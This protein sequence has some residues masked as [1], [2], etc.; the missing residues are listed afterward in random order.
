MKT[1]KLLVGYHKPATLLKNDFLVPIHLG[2]AVAEKSA[3]DGQL[4][5]KELQWMFDNM[6]GDNTGENISHLNREFCEL[7]GLYWA[8]KN[9][10]ALENPDYIGFMHYR[11]HFVLNQTL[12]NNSMPDNFNLIRVPY[13]GENY[14]PDISLDKK[15]LMDRLNTVDGIYSASE[16]EESP[17]DYRKNHHSG[18]F[19][20]YRKCLDILERK[21]TGF[22]E[23]SDE[24]NT[25][26]KHFWSQMFILS[27]ED[28]LNYC[29]WLFSILIE[30]HATIDYSE[31][32]AYQ[33]RAVAYCGETLNGIWA[34]YS[35]KKQYKLW[36]YYPSTFVKDPRGA[37]G[38]ENMSISGGIPIVFTA[39]R[40]Y[41]LYIG[42]AI[43][44]IIENKEN[45]TQYDIIIL[46]TG[47]TGFQKEKLEVLSRHDVHVRVL[48]VAEVC[49]KYKMDELM[50]IHHLNHAAYI[51]LLLCEI[52]KNYH[53]VIYLDSDLVVLTD[54]SEVYYN[55]DLSRN[56]AAVVKDYLIR[57]VFVQRPEFVQYMKEVLHVDDLDMYFN[58]GVMIL[59]LDLMRADGIQ[60]RLLEV[61]RINNKY[62]H[63]QNVLNSVLYKK[64]VY[65]DGVY[66][67]NY[68]LYFDM[69]RDA[70]PDSYFDE[71]RRPKILHY[72]SRNKPWRK[73]ELPAS[74]IF[75]HYARLTPLYEEIVYA[76]LA[77]KV[78]NEVFATDSFR[79][80]I[81]EVLSTEAFK[82]AVNSTFAT[83]SF[84]KAIN[85]VFSTEAFKKAVNTTFATG[86]FRE[87]V[88]STFATDAFRR[89]VNTNTK[90]LVSREVLKNV[91][92][93]RK[94]LLKF[95]FYRFLS[96]ITFG[97]TRE[98]YMKKKRDNRA[99]VRM[100]R[101]LSK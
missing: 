53:K 20:E 57:S 93:Y 98:R 4:S 29:E 30:L 77:K 47:L 28:F 80:A 79:R 97:K 33:R 45:E 46:E 43:Q 2:R 9:Y 17:Y 22:K 64:V 1:I 66:N 61:A 69:Y 31:Y 49:K 65:L 50:T 21:Y 26:R 74:G 18:T 23:I 6:I 83:D 39:D 12:I 91:Q 25:G 56:Y 37:M 59:N 58:S 76:N 89:A 82:N 73:P 3:K 36:G 14:L 100:V 78:V 72:A 8:W 99:K 92:N 71:F 63:D 60:G 15:T 11:R 48:D 87:A 27:G 16:R 41:Y 96:K 95:Y 101:Q 52:L 62:F 35:E 13:I 10:A 54:L 24:Y 94:S 51:R 88:H 34:S 90:T 32:N 44:S 5:D 42:V 19:R 70:I 75:W 86:S 68:F 55:T 67:V 38:I 85:E 81:D 40:N 7:T 84:R